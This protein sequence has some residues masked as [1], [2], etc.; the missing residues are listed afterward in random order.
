M[1]LN[2]MQSRALK[3]DGDHVLIQQRCKKEL[4]CPV[5]R[6]EADQ[7]KKT[8]L[9]KHTVVLGPRMF[10][11]HFLFWINILYLAKWFFKDLK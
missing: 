9:I 11:Q 3:L 4:A 5:A 2:V 10:L 6:R 1:L 8:D 7:K